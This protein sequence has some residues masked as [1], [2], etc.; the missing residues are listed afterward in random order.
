MI[1]TTNNVMHSLLFQASLPARYWAESL[2][3]VIYILNLLP[4]KAISAPTPY[5][6]FLPPLPPT[7]TFGS[8]GVPATRTS[9]PLLP[10]S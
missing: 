5:F 2:Y 7:P 6:A 9:L 1:H 4:T 3:T 10:I 8:S